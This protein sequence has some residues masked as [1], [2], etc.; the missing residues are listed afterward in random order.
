MR[1]SL[2]SDILPGF[3]AAM[4]GIDVGRQTC[5]DID[6]GTMAPDYLAGTRIATPGVINRTVWFSFS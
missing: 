2:V 3:V 1:R 4:T 6:A 5:T